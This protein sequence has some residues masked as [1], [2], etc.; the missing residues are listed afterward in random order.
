MHQHKG[1]SSGRT[2]HPDRLRKGKVKS[3]VKCEQG[4]ELCGPRC[5]SSMAPAHIIRSSAGLPP[6][7]GSATEKSMSI[8]VKSVGGARTAV[9]HK[10]QLDVGGW[11]PH[12]QGVVRNR[13]WWCESR[14]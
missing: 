14:A 7:S 5:G 10:H 13:H 8:S 1:H 4:H 11:G 12:E 2:L 9:H 6:D 3:G